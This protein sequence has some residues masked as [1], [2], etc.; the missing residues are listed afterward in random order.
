MS[1]TSVKRI[2]LAVASVTA[3][4]VLSTSAAMAATTTATFTVSATVVSTCNVTTNNLNFGTYSGASATGAS[5]VNATCSTGTPYTV[6]L[7]Q[8]ASTGATVTTRKMAGPGAEYLNYGLFQDAGHATNWGNTS[9]TDTQAST[10]TGAAQS[11]TVYGQIPASQFVQAGA[12]SDT[13][14]ATLTF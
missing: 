4:T 11:F 5:T 9:G 3:V 10:G 13:I 14:T 8:G 12:Y 7:N 2:L 1:K 6:G